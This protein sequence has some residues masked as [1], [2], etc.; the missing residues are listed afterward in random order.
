MQYNTTSIIL[1]RDQIFLGWVDSIV[2]HTEST[3]YLV[4]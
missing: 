2:C 4:G 1:M 3:V